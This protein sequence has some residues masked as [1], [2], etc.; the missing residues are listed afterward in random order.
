MVQRQKE[1][2]MDDWKPAPRR[3]EIP[4]WEVRSMQDARYRLMRSAEHAF[5]ND[6]TS[7][8]WITNES[9]QKLAKLNNIEDELIHIVEWVWNNHRHRSS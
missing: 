4:D 7:E 3:P 5:Y 9:V 2:G 1:H 6:I 8:A